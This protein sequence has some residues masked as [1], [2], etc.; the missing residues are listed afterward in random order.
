MSNAQVL[1]EAVVLSSVADGPLYRRIK[2][3]RSGL[4]DRDALVESY[5]TAGQYVLVRVD[6]V[7]ETGFFAMARAPGQLADGLEILVKLQGQVAESL[8][9]LQPGDVLQMSDPIGMGYPL[10]RA[11]GCDVLVLAAGSGIAPV[12]AALEVLLSERDEYG[13]IRLYYG[14]ARSQELAFS[15]WLAALPAR[16]V[17]VHKV[18]SQD[19]PG[20]DEDRGYVQAVADVDANFAAPRRL[21]V[22]VCGMPAMERDVRERCRARGLRD[23][24]IL[25]NL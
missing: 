23:A 18:I 9:A 25:T 20:P 5:R 14:Q 7:E 6:A 12:R 15:E 21:A 8:A 24:Q 13:W 11:S 10:E 17:E 22:I 4:D 3:S 1:P 2:V 16:G 19:E